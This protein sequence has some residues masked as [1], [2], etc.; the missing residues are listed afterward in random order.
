[1]SEMRREGV[2]LVVSGPSGVGKGT[3][4]ERLMLRHPALSRSVS[5]T[6]RRPRPG[7]E[8]GVHYSFVSTEEFDRMRRDG[9]L[10]E[11]AVV[12]QDLFYGTPRIPVEQAMAEG[13][14]IILEIDYQGAVSV[15]KALGEQAV[16]VFVA[17][18]SWEALENRLRAR[19]TED[20][21][22]TKKRLASAIHELAHIDIFEYL[23]INDN[24]EHAVDML[25]A[26]LV[27]EQHRVS[28]TNWE[29]LVEDLQK[30]AGHQQD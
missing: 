10:L 12:H 29:P 18:P 13:R 28:R 23:I 9:E 8:D 20:E 11:W 26:V 27:A 4:I 21:E 1:M 30:A 15:R 14:D 22:A 7:E 5:C 16:L 19:S 17:P 25:E 6:T 24:L 2:L 3:V